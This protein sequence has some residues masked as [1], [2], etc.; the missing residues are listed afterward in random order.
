MK[1]TF[2]QSTSPALLDLMW[3]AFFR[4]R[5]RGRLFGEHFPWLANP[6]SA[7]AWFATIRDDR[8][9][10]V[11]GLVVKRHFDHAD[12]ASIGLVCVRADLRGQGLSHSLVSGAIR[13]AAALGMTRLTLWTGKPSVYLKH[14]FETRD[15]ALFGWVRN[16]DRSS[17][18]EA[19][20]SSG[21]VAW[22]DAAERREKNR[23]LPAFAVEAYRLMAGLNRAQA[24][25]VV[26][27]SGPIVAEWSGDDADVAQLLRAALPASWRLNALHGD[28]L[29]AALK[30]GGIDVD[31]GA[32]R[33]QMW[34]TSH[35]ALQTA[36][37]RLR[38]LDR[39]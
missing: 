4:E 32:S 14:G 17:S 5:G 25:V 15:P 23:G 22:P 28:S 29:I 34:Q 16:T 3:S 37:P 24:I 20:S 33:L 38:L 9:Q 12:T 26:D 30:S 27:G 13:E 36:L 21:R 11:A 31:L 10:P 2:D 8:S 7:D 6:R 39:I 1:L 19:A 35:D 18:S